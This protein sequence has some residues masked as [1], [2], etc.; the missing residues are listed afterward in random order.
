MNP[1]TKMMFR[2]QKIVILL[3]V[4]WWI[5]RDKL[6]HIGWLHLS[7][8]QK[9]NPSGHLLKD[10]RWSYTT[11][12]V[13]S[14]LSP[15]PPMVFFVRISVLETWRLFFLFLWLISK[16]YDCILQTWRETFLNTFSTFFLSFFFFSFFF[17]SFLFFFFNLETK[18]RPASKTLYLE[19]FWS[20]SV[21]VHL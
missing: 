1:L 18:E 5:I 19:R 8:D 7:G 14:S 12:T 9:W 20:Y 17:F 4:L 11:L 13:S 21:N 6:F 16:F 15:R 2:K 3:G 10:S